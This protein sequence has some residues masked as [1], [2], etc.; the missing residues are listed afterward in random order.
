VSEEGQEF[1]NF[2]Q[3]FCFPNFEWQKTNFTTFGPP[4]EKRFEKFT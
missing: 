1:E 4:I 3:K 2:S